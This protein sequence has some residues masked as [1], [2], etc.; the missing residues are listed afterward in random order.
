MTECKNNVHKNSFLFVIFI[1]HEFLL[2]MSVFCLNLMNIYY[3]AYHSCIYQN[4]QSLVS[5]V[6]YMFLYKFVETLFLSRKECTITFHNK[7]FLKK[8]AFFHEYYLIHVKK[9]S[10]GTVVDSFLFC[11][12]LIILRK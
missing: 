11:T 4:L 5:H 3:Q 2:M 12:V 8:K 9:K 6:V 1:T 7:T 10:I